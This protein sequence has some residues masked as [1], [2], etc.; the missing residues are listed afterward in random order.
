MNDE[1]LMHKILSRTV[2]TSSCWFYTG[3][4]SSG[5]GI[6]IVDGRER[7]AHRVSYELVNGKVPDGMEL[8]HLCAVKH[9]I[10]PEHLQAVTHLENSRRGPQSLRKE[11]KNYLQPSKKKTFL[12]Y[13]HNERFR[14][15]D[16]KSALVNRLLEA[17]YK[18][19][20]VPQAENTIADAINRGDIVTYGEVPKATSTCPHG[21]AKGF[22]KKADCN[23]KYR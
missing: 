16:K 21:S 10:N 22:C 4:K 17:H 18:N 20:S 12:L 3:T 11:T 5:Y 15:E 6:V 13:I 19:I 1:Q 7:V 14:D 9:C 23:K 8:D 2:K